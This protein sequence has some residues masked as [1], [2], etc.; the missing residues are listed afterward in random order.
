MKSVNP[1]TGET[2]KIYETLDARQIGA[3]LDRAVKAFAEWKR[4]PIEARARH[5]VRAAGILE[6]KAQELGRLMTLE[7]GKPIGAAEDEARKCARGCRFYAEHAAGFLADES[8]AT[9]A[10]ASYVRYEP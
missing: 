8:I 3:R 2:L 10:A 7:M 4:T 9:E 5:M 6:Q 1:A